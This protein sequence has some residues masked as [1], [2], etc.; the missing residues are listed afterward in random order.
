MLKKDGQSN[1]YNTMHTC[2]QPISMYVLGE[3]KEL[4][5]MIARQKKGVDYESKTRMSESDISTGET[6]SG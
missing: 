5:H 2:H 1:Q 4:H 6:D 3:N